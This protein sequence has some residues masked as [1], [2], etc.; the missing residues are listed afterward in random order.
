MSTPPINLTQLEYQQIYDNIKAYIKSK[1]D[2][3]DFDFD[4]SAVSK[5]FS[6]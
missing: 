1:S 3:T 2:F 4:G 6:K 5:Y